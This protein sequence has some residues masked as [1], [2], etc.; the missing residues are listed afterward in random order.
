MITIG[1]IVFDEK[2]INHKTLPYVQYQNVL[3]TPKAA[4]LQLPTLTIGW[5]L[6]NKLF[7]NKNFDILEREFR[8]NRPEQHFW[9]FSATE[10]IVQYTNGLDHFIK[11]LPYLFISNFQYKNAD[12]FFNELFS[13]DAI[14]KFLP[15]GGFLYVYKNEMAYY[16]IDRT[17]YGLKLPMYQYIGIDSNDLIQRLCAKSKNHRLDDSTDYQTYYKQFPEFGYLKRSMVVFLF[18]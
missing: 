12:P 4:P 5:K 2:L 9:E 11:K 13:I 18:S 14:D 10:D 7:P 16:L 6:V 8:L 3:E 17:I 1:K 15:D